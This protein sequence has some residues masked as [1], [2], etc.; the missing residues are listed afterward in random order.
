MSV[1]DFYLQIEELDKIENHQDFK[2]NLLEICQ[3]LNSY[4]YMNEKNHIDVKLFELQDIL[5]C[6]INNVDDKVVTI[7]RLIDNEADENVI[8]VFK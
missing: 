2:Y 8:K 3:E 7:Q 6:Y 5:D 1:Y 4:V